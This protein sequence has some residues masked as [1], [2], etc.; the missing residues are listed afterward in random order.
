MMNLKFRN[1]AK[2][3]EEMWVER[4]FLPTADSSLCS[5]QSILF[6]KFALFPSNSWTR[7]VVKNLKV[8]NHRN[9]A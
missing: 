1:S 2:S 7:V 3:T 5:F 8:K 4:H 6:D 9:G